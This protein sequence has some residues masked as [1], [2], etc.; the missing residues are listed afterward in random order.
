MNEELNKKIDA[1]QE[2]IDK[3]YQSVEKT[4]KYFLWTFII[5]IVV[6]VL[7]LIVMLLILPSII[8][9]YS[10]TLNGLNF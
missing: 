1:Q 10:N 9:S 6:F 5:T 8:S 7:P 2:K 3:I 4:R